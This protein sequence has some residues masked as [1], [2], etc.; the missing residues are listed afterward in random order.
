MNPYQ[1]MEASDAS[2][3]AYAQQTGYTERDVLHA[4]NSFQLE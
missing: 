2:A 3:R 1:L 4:D